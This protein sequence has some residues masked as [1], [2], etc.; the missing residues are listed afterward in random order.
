MAM[1]AVESWIFN[2]LLVVIREVLMLYWLLHWFGYGALCFM[3]LVL[4][5]SLNIFLAKFF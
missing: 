3:Y 2:A 5:R 1:E 4:G